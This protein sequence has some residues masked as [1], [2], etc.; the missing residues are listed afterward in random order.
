ML[1]IPPTHITPGVD[2]DLSKASLSMHGCSTPENASAFYGP[3]MQWLE[4]HLPGSSGPLIF[5]V[6]LT[7]FTSSSLKALFKMMQQVQGVR[8]A[9]TPIEVH[10]YAEED[11][12]V[13]DTVAMLREVLGLPIELLPMADGKDQPVN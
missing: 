6:R 10:W 7:S 9:G 13:V 8:A 12:D 3:L 5:E 4:E 11:D 1:Q 2:L